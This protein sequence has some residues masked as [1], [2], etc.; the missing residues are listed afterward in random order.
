MQHL[1]GFGCAR[2][3]V[4]RVASATACVGLGHARLRFQGR[5]LSRCVGRNSAVA[6]Y[7]V[8]ALHAARAR[9]ALCRPVVAILAVGIIAPLTHFLSIIALKLALLAILAPRL[10]RNGLMLARTTVFAVCLFPHIPAA[11]LT[12]RASL[13]IRGLLLGR[14]F[15]SR[16]VLAR[17]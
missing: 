7:A 1:S 3:V 6:Q 15:A 10:A 17:W 16:A 9:D 2:E 13:A 8:A 11:K 4:R 14:E 5:R 12:C